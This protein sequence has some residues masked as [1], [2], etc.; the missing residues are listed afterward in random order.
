[1][2][3]PSTFDSFDA[4][5]LGAV[6]ES[7]L[8]ARGAAP[9]LPPAIWLC[10]L[11]SATD[12]PIWRIDGATAENINGANT[13]KV[14]STPNNT[15][16]FGGVL[17][18]GGTLYVGGKYVR[19]PSA[20]SLV[21]GEGIWLYEWNGTD[22]VDTTWQTGEPSDPGGG[23]IADAYTDAAGETWILSYDAAPAEFSSSTVDSAS[24]IRR[25]SS[26]GSW[27]N[28][29][30]GLV[31]GDSVV[32]T[33]HISAFA[34]LGGVLYSAHR[35]ETDDSPAF[36]RLAK[37]VG[38]QW[39]RL[40]PSPATG[41][42]EIVT[43]ITVWG[44]VLAI[45]YR[46]AVSSYVGASS[47]LSTQRRVLTFDGTSAAVTSQY[48]TTSGTFTRPFV[49]AGD[50]YIGRNNLIL[51]YNTGTSTW[52]T[53]WSAATGAFQDLFVHDGVIYAAGSF[54][55]LDGSGANYGAFWDGANWQQL[56]GPSASLIRAKFSYA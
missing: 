29:T 50:L 15:S 28:A 51:K 43:S 20:E 30:E 45:G 52:A 55:D 53:E 49:L 3:P 10:A 24:V 31:A 25:A 33:A 48:A 2:A 47:T 35:S 6:S 16:L 56:P 11:V 1:M 36:G 54:T 7:A 37:R 9:A 22:F 32:A 21:A 12:A 13:L 44:S 4:S 41:A 17:R 14:R 27:S 26:P 40:E 34:E 46:D 19:R 18:I 23:P 5:A 39:V 42:N 8:H 38:G